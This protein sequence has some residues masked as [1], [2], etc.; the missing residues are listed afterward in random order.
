MISKGRVCARGDTQ[1]D[2][3]VFFD[4]YAPVAS[5]PAVRISLVYTVKRRL[6]LLQADVPSAYVKAGLREKIY[7]R[8]VKGF[9]CPGKEQHVYLLR[10][11]RYGLRQAGAEWHR[12]IDAT[13]RSLGLH[14]TRADSC[15]YFMPSKR[16]LV[17]LYA[18]DILFAY[19]DTR[20]VERLFSVL[21]VKYQIKNFGRPTKVLGMSLKITYDSIKLT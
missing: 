12:E 21:E 11:A 7:M 14:P 5:L 18:D 2:H 15:L 3:Y 13:L 17:F 20:V 8:Q 4:V 19:E 6:Q 9:K 1:P 16:F 10:R